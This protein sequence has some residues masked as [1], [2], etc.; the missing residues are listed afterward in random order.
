MFMVEEQK[1]SAEEKSQNAVDNQ[2]GS[3][4]D[5][6][7]DQSLDQSTEVQPTDSTL[8]NQVN[9]KKN[10]SNSKKPPA[11]NGSQ[12]PQKPKQGQPTDPKVKQYVLRINTSD[13]QKWLMYLLIAMLF[14]PFFMSLFQSNAEI[15]SLSQM[16][17]DV[18]EEKIK[19]I[20][21]A[22]ET[23]NLTYTEEGVVKESRKESSQNI[24]GILDS[25][26]IDITETDVLITDLSLT[27]M[28]KDLFVNLLPILLMV[29]VFFFIFRQAR[30]AQDGM[31]GIGRSKAKLFV[32]G[33]QD[34]KFAD[35]GGM[36]E[37]KKELEEIVDFMKQPKKY[38]KVGA[39]T[40]KG[41]L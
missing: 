27:D 5:S 8:T 32:K 35:V 9:T 33:K 29:G 26:G 30:G 31:M 4:V 38:T 13:W 37:A 15:I 7:G 20:Q 16:I 22:G 1:N 40:P 19:E 21:V 11:K 2:A 41:V 18:R 36:D 14:L 25:A 39:R 24:V 6:V 17:T 23:L 12:K 34:T 28:L 3:S 10:N